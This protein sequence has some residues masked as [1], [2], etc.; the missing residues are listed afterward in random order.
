MANDQIELVFTYGS[1]K[2]NWITA[3]TKTF[4]QGHFKITSGKVI[5][6]T[7]IPM[8]SGEATQE[9]LEGKR[10]AHLCSP[11]SA[12]FIELAN[13]ESA[14]QGG[15]NLIGPTQSLVRSPVVIAMWKPM[16]EALGWGKKPLGWAEIFNMANQPEGWAA[17]DNPEWGKFKFGHTHPKFSNSG[18]ISLLAEVYAGSGKTKNLTAADVN[19]SDVRHYIETIEKSVVHYGSSTGFFGDKMFTYGPAF[20]SAAVLYENLVIDSYNPQYKLPFPIVTIYPQEGTFWSD[21]PIGVVEREW[22]TEEHRQAAK[23]YIDYLLAKP[24]QEK[25]ISYGFRPADNNIQLTAPIDEAHGVNPTEPTTLLEVPPAYIIRE[26][27][28]L[29]NERKK[30]ANV[31]LALDISGSMMGDK[32]NHARQGALKFLQALG[33]SDNVS[34]LTFNH[35][36]NWLAKQLPLKTERQFIE[37]KINNLFA[38]GNTALY[39]AITEAYQYLKKNPQAEKIA[40]VV[41]LSDGQDTSSQLKLE[42]LLKQIQLTEATSILIFPIGYG[43][44]ADKTVLA[45]I[46]NETKTKVYPGTVQDIEKVFLEISTFF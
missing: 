45:N 38:S 29:W 4:N 22:V 18:L 20:L 44:D 34:L 13:A 16:A 21:H 19:N 42:E 26:I 25:A 46:A 33:D 6:V 2:E 5:Q 28:T 24:Q 37:K 15:K 41:V 40:A 30:N 9:L 11:A 1:E 32:L 43:E 35:E 7:A 14:D 17:Y 39:D 31:V 10:Q 8:G 3:V 36:I 27:L 12:A 23:V